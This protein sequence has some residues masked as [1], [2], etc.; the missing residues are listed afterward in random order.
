MITS[1]TLYIFSR[2]SSGARWRLI[3]FYWAFFETVAKSRTVRSTDEINGSP[4][5]DGALLL[6]VPI[7]ISRTLIVCSAKRLAGL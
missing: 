2:W 3:L 1:K 6:R 4:A 7:C 5:F